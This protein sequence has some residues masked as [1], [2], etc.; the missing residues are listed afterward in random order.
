MTDSIFTKLCL[1]F[2]Y[3]AILILVPLFLDYLFKISIR[4]NKKK[5]LTELAKARAQKVKK[6]LI[7]FNGVNGGSIDTDGKVES[8]DGNVSEIVSQ[9]GDNTS[10]V[11]VAETLEYIPDLQNFIKELKRISDGDL[12]ILGVENNSPR[13]FWD[14]KIINVL[15]K[16]YF[17]A[18][19]DKE[20]TWGSPNS[21]Q[22]KTQKIY[23][24]VFNILPYDMIVNKIINA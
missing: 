10:V 14:Y 21:L 5:E 7:I 6:P 3:V 23:E 11:L 1:I 19:K 17:V 22:L 12:Y 13:I 8:F 2:L 15:D 18:K 9:L 16:S 4:R 24:Y 20:I